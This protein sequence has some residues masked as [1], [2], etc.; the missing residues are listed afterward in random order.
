MIQNGD[1]EDSIEHWGGDAGILFLLCRPITITNGNFV[2]G[3]VSHILDVGCGKGS[4]IAY[5]RNQSPNSGVAYHLGKK[6]PFKIGREST[7]HQ[8]QTNHN[9]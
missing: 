4:L 7:S 1:L 9:L 2:G 3:K 8:F 6:F 5:A